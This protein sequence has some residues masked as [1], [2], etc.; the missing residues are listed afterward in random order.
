MVVL[1]MKIP[2]VKSALLDKFVTFVVHACVWDVLCGYVTG[3][4]YPKTLTCPSFY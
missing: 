4:F 3:S 2:G 1:L